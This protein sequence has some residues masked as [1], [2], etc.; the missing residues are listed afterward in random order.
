ESPLLERQ[1]EAPFDLRPVDVKPLR[2]DV[3]VDAALTI[4]N[5]EARLGAEAGLILPSARV[6]AAHRTLALALG[7]AVLDHAM[8]YAVRARI[9]E[10]AVAA[11]GALGVQ[12]Y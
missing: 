10:V 5:R 3:D 8:P 9:V 12:R 4:G 6:D 2:R 11:R 7:V 1:V